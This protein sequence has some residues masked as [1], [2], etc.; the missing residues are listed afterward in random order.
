[1]ADQKGI[2][3]VEILVTLA[4][5][6]T[7]SV[8]AYPHLLGWRQRASLQSDVAALVGCLRMAKMEAIK[9]NA[10]V[11]VDA[12]PTGFSVFVDNSSNPDEFEDWFRQEQERELCNCQLKSGAALS[13]NFPDNKMRFGN[14]SGIRAGRFSLTDKAG[15]RT[16]IILNLIGRIRV[17][18]NRNAAL[19]R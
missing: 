2:T 12:Q 5:L 15:G 11:V 14:K 8:I 3:L 6:S 16:E 13:S 9:A 19:A 1:M 7:L 18:Y 4:I 17:E 10:F